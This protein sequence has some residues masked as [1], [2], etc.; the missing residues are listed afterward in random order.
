M[1]SNDELAILIKAQNATASAFQG[2]RQ[3]LAG[4]GQETQKTN[5]LLGGMKTALGAIGGAFVATQVLGFVKDVVASAGAI[6][7]MSDRL[8]IGTTAVQRF[9]N[10][11][12]LGGGS[13]E[14]VGKAINKMNLNLAGGKDSTKEALAAAGLSFDKIRAMQPEAAFEAIAD[15]VSSIVD[16]AKRAEVATVLLGKGAADL[17]PTLGAIKKTSDAGLI[18][19]ENIKALDYLGDAFTSALQKGKAFGAWFAGGLVRDIQSGQ[20]W[21]EKA[22]LTVTLG[23]EGATEALRQQASMS[24]A[25]A[26]QVEAAE[27]VKQEAFAKAVDANEKAAAATKKKEDADKQAAQAAKQHADAIG[28]LR[29]ELTGRGAIKAALDMAEALRGSLAIG[30]LSAEAQARIN[31]TMGEAID[32]YQRFGQTVPPAVQAAFIAT[33]HLADATAGLTGQFEHV[34]VQLERFVVPAIFDYANALKYVNGIQSGVQVGKQLPIPTAPTP[35]KTALQS[36]FG[37]ASQFGGDIGNVLLKAIT[38]GGNA[39]QSAGALIGQKLTS[40]LAAKL[41]TGVAPM[42]TGVFGGAVNAIL[43]GLGT[44]VGPLTEKLF[45]LFNQHHGRDLVKDFAG[46]FGGFDE[47][48]KVLAEKLPADAEKFWIMLTQGVGRNNPTQAKAAIDAITAALD[49]QAHKQ[50]DVAAA[51]SKAAEE[52]D[53]AATK[54]KDAMKG[55]DDQISSLQESIAGEAPEE[56]MGVVERETRDRIARLSDERKLLEEQLQQQQADTKAATEDVGTSVEDVTSSA[57]QALDIFERWT[58]AIHGAS[59]AL[60]G[61]RFPAGFEAPATVPGYQSGTSHVEFV[62]FGPPNLTEGSM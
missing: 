51:A 36:I 33:T 32:A 1:P 49:A 45:S 22:Y 2:A 30:S 26:K 21:V 28:R 54:I 27:K 4:L 47:L 5:Q 40:S 60:G 37:S 10:A 18:S 6:A 8:G 61:M 15:G 50:D 24:A 39:V 41:T 3:Q 19:P 56:F 35:P 42:L 14:D 48:H 55:I 29:D 31:K 7:D 38:G 17:L 13:M 43:P 53:K 11:A 25:T 57:E 16:P 59:D 46:Q 62:A 44:L 20:N 52:Q 23:S 34:G 12:E 58:G 9:T